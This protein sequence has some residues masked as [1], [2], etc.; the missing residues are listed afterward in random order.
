MKIKP[1]RMVVLIFKMAIAYTCL[2]LLGDPKTE[3]HASLKF[4]YQ[5]FLKLSSGHH[6]L[7]VLDIMTLTFNEDGPKTLGF[8][9]I[10]RP[11]NTHKVWS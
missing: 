9:G 2:V 1:Y 8:W 3:P 11:I 4:M 7:F 10:P 6:F 5:I